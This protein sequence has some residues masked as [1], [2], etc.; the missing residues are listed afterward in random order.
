MRG[1]IA[2]VMGITIQ[3]LVTFVAALVIAFTSSWKMTLVVLSVVPLLGFSSWMQIKFFTGAP[4]A[5]ARGIRCLCV[6]F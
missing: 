1:A 5:L 3:N 2:D 6:S 4:R